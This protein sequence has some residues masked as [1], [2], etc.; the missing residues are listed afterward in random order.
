MRDAYVWVWVSEFSA[1]I[2]VVRLA[3]WFSICVCTAI[4]FIWYIHTCIHT[5]EYMATANRIVSVDVR[6]VLVQVELLPLLLLLLL[7]FLLLFFHFILNFDYTA[8]T[9]M[10]VFLDS[11]C[12]L[13]RALCAFVYAYKST[14]CFSFAFKC[15][16]STF[17]HSVIL[18]L[19]FPLSFSTLFTRVTFGKSCRR[20]S[21]III[22]ICTM[23]IKIN[24]T[25]LW[26][27]KYTLTRSFTR[28]LAHSLTA[29]SLVTH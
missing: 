14:R 4:A 28:S 9:L 15:S 12:P 18:I 10:S 27:W 5:L 16:Q 7:L 21:Q 13:I 20:S 22:I 29:S 19:A 6:G 2:A 25:H 3:V 11:W 23:E 1:F 24:L 17:I 8:N 26:I